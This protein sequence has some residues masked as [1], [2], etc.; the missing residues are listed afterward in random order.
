MSGNSLKINFVESMDLS[1]DARP[2]DRPQEHLCRSFTAILLEPEARKEQVSHLNNCIKGFVYKKNE[3][4]QGSVTGVLL[5]QENVFVLFLEARFESQTE[6]LRD[7]LLRLK[8]EPESG[9]L[10]VKLLI[11]NELFKHR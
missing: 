5:H 2:S 7:Q 11:F 8:R 9:I 1:S 10:N 3:E 4:K 6:L